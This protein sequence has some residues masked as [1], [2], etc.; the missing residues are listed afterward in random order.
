MGHAAAVGDD[1]IDAVQV[2]FTAVLGAI[3]VGI[4][5]QVTADG[6]RLVV[7]IIAR[8]S[9]AA[10]DRGDSGW[11]GAFGLGVTSRVIGVGFIDIDGG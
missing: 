10:C 5:I 4:N 7:A 9:I 8:V 11:V 2:G 3:T 6:A 1:D